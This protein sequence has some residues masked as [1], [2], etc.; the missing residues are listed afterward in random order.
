MNITAIILTFNEEKN[1]SNCLKSIIGWAK[2]VIVVDS[3]SKDKTIEIAK[4]L[5]CE[6]FFNKYIDHSSQW[7]WCLSNLNID[8]DWVMPLDADHV[9]SEKLKKQLEDEIN[10]SQKPVNGF[11]ASHRYIFMGK[12]IR[13]FKPHTII[14][15]KREK[16]VLDSSE[17]VDFHF[18]IEE[19]VEILDGI[20]YEINKN[21]D[22]IDFWIDK[23]QN[24][25][26]R[27]AVE[28]VLRKYKKLKWKIQPSIFGNPNQKIIF[29]KSIWYKLPLLLRPFIYF[30]YRYFLKLGI[31]DGKVGLIYHFLHAFWFRFIIDVKIIQLDRAIKNN[32]ISL[33]N[34][35]IE[36]R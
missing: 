20:L 1:I 8:T 35:I 3:G 16:T 36:Y 5:G 23:H 22:E 21:E 12:R 32:S 34:L 19:P 14:A 18:S 6:V 27:I 29:L 13:G 24:F 30:F 11:F 7:K 4:D 15:F 9:V 33:E 26:T 10:F 2:R 31:F 25:S 17:L 28:E